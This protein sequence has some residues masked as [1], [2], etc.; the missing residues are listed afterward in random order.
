MKIPRF[1]LEQFQQQDFSCTNEKCKSPFILA[2]LVFLGIKPVKRNKQPVKEYLYCDYLCPKCNNKAGFEIF[3]MKLEEFAMMILDDVDGLEEQSEPKVSKKKTFKPQENQEKKEKQ[4]IQKSK[5][6]TQETQ[7]AA[8][9]LDSAKSWTEWLH[10]IG[11]PSEPKEPE[12]NNFRI[13]NQEEEN[14]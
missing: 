7:T 13:N 4:S 2:G 11:I 9:M 14:E 1:L 5:I 3:E 6:S 8:K 10:K 12:K